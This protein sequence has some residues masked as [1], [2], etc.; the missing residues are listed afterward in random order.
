MYSIDTTK[1]IGKM[2]DFSRLNGIII[3]LNNPKTI[4][5]K[6][7]LNKNVNIKNYQDGERL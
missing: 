3:D 1:Y 6:L 2:L 7:D 4:Q 5:D